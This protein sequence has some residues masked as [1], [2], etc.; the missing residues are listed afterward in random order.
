MI[1]TDYHTSFSF[2]INVAY[3]II[4][5]ILWR[6][7]RYAWVVLSVT[8]PRFAAG[9][10]LLSLTQKKLFISNYNLIVYIYLH[11]VKIR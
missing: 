8:S 2:V 7:P 11:I 4:S 3:H 9:Y 1:T 10:P 5:Q 6:A